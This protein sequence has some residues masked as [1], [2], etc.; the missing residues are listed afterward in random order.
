VQMW[1]LSEGGGAGGIATATAL[2]QDR[3]R[4]RTALGGA[5]GCVRLPWS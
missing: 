1:L 4:E 5:T 2:S 3:T